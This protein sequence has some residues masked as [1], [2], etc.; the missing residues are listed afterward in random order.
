MNSHPTSYAAEMLGALRELEPDQQA[1]LTASAA[2]AS[3][4]MDLP[5]NGTFPVLIGMVVLLIAGGAALCFIRG[6]FGPVAAGVLV[7][8]IILAPVGLWATRRPNLRRLEQ[9]QEE[10]DLLVAGAMDDPSRLVDALRKLERVELGSLG[11][12]SGLARFSTYGKRRERLERR[13]GLR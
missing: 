12:A 9:Q 11:A 1:A 2:R 8:V 5:A 13:L 3:F 7:L 6:P 10:A 4:E